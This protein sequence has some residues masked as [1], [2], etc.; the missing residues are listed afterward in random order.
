MK[1][2]PLNTDSWTFTYPQAQGATMQ[3]YDNN[4]KELIINRW[5][6]LVRYTITE[7]DLADNDEFGTYM[8]EAMEVDEE[9]DVGAEFHIL[10]FSNK[11][12]S[13]ACSDQDDLF[14][15]LKLL[16]EDDHNSQW[17]TDINYNELGEREDELSEAYQ[18]GDEVWALVE[19]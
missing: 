13:W 14:A 12:N 9:G 16:G 10:D 7:A 8:L 5:N 15:A 6:K 17:T 18:V 4:K 3:K 19:R 11:F 1:L 2:I